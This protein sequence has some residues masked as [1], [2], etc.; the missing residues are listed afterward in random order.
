MDHARQSTKNISY[1][2]TDQFWSLYLTQA[3]VQDQQRIERWK[4]ESDGILIFTGLFA[5]TVATFVV[6]YYPKLSPDSGDETVALLVQ[7]VVLLSNGTI[8]PAFAMNSAPSGSATFD[9]F[10]PTTSDVW[11]NALWFLSLVVSISC[12]LLATLV[13]QW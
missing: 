1:S 3:Q 4:G 12:A 10:G 5:A 11:V 13:R 6:A 9:S 7:V 8:T 2:N